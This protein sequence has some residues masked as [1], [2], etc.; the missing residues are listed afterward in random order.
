[1]VSLAD[2]RFARAPAN[3]NLSLPV[4]LPRG[5]AVPE[6]VT[7][8]VAVVLAGGLIRRHRGR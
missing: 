8:G 5:S 7:G 4:G 2:G 1:L 6:P 3:F